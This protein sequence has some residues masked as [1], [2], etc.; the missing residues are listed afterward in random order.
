[1]GISFKVMPGVRV[2]LTRKG[3]N[4]SIGPRVA[5]AHVSSSGVSYSS[6]VGPITV[7]GG[8]RRRSRP[9]VFGD[10]TLLGS[11]DEMSIAERESYPNLTPEEIA[12]LLDA[13]I[14]RMKSRGWFV[15]K[16]SDTDAELSK[17]R[18]SIPRF[19]FASSLLASGVYATN[20]ALNSNEFVRWYAI[21]FVT[22]AVVTVVL[23]DLYFRKTTYHKL[24]VN[25]LGALR[26]Q[27]HK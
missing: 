8:G 12:L 10:A 6:G 11:T 23:P 9:S 19:L 4:A 5:R 27:F 21:G 1:M 15:L 18:R 17:K 2:G 3:M 13:E 16:K 22:L 25:E 14:E 7:S 26:K 24:S 20:W